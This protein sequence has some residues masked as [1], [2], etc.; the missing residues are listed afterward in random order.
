[1]GIDEM[2]ATGFISDG[3]FIVTGLHIHMSGNEEGIADTD[4]V[5]VDLICG[6]DDRQVEMED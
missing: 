1:M 4:R 3:V 2:T 6:V 5:V